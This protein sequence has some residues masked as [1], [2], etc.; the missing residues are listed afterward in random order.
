MASKCKRTRV[1]FPP[2]ALTVCIVAAGLWFVLPRPETASAGGA[3][4]TQDL[5]LIVETLDGGLEGSEQAQSAFTESQFQLI[6]QTDGAGFEVNGDT[7]CVHI[8]IP[9]D[10]SFH[11]VFR[12]GAL[13]LNDPASPEAGLDLDATDGYATIYIPGVDY[14]VSVQA[15]GKPGGSITWG[16]VWRLDPLWK[17]HTLIR[18]TG[19]L[20]WEGPWGTHFYGGFGRWISPPFENDRL[21]C[22][23]MHWLA[24]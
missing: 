18:N 13:E 14:D 7:V 2:R 6:L 20:T 21:S 12:E 4:A 17:V 23:A 1:G 24:L 5:P 16:Q 15:R 9:E 11:I 19:R 3:P 10:S 22:L 8:R